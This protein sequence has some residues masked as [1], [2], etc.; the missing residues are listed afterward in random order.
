[1]RRTS[2]LILYGF[3]VPA[4]LYASIYAAFSYPLLGSFSTHY[5][6][7]QEDGYQNIWNLWWLNKSV[8]QLHQLPWYTTYLQYPVGTTLI[9]HTL[10]PFNGL[11][12]IPLSKMGFTLNQVYNLVV[13][14]SFV[15][16]GVT[17]F[18]LAWRVSGSYVG[19]LFAG[20][21]F[22]FC[23]FHFAHAQ[24]HL[25][26]VTLEWLPLATL[27]IYELLSRPTVLKGIGAAVAMLLVAMSDFHL[28]FYVVVAGSL[29]GIVALARQFRSGFIDVKKFVIP[30]SLFVILTSASTGLL[31]WKLL[32]VNK[33]DEL[34]Q[35]HDPAIWSTDVI[36]PIVPSAQWRFARLTQGVWGR[37]ATPDKGFVYVEHSLY[38]GWVVLLLCG[39]VLLRYRTVGLKDGG[40]WFGL[41]LFFFLLSLGPKLHL[42]GTVSNFPGIY[43]VLEKLFPPLKVGG[44]PMRMMLMVNLSGAVIAAAALGDLIRMSR[45]WAWAIVPLIALA[46]AFESLPKAQPTTPAVYPK[47][48]EKLRELPDGA[49]IDTHYKTELS[50]PLY[51][52]TGYGKPMGEGY[53]SRYPKSVEVRRG[54]FRA[55]VDNWNFDKLRDEWKFRYLVIRLTDDQGR[56]LPEL[57]YKVVY[58]EAKDRLRV[59]DLTQK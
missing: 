29:L 32:Q 19:A 5:F 50:A 22:T 43:P 56:A 17:A 33:T 58:R 1:M 13:I 52:A 41:M 49:V 3:I 45:R 59:Y 26:M 7:G 37:L 57:P 48:V 44:V 15:M 20:A 39:W 53:I 21:A 38:V 47:W 24:N 40:Y 36:D 27:A 31:A 14:F 16:T 2:L 11:I 12:A 10:A 25:Q 35:N 54:E 46:W 4:A 30:L 34:Q 6:C 51:Y 23:H 42:W 28:T 9:A 8:T 18:W 55:L